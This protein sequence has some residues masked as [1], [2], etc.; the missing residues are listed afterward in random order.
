MKCYFNHEEKYIN[1]NPNPTKLPL[2]YQL[3]ID[4]N[5]DTLLVNIACCSIK[6]LKYGACIL[7]V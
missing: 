4:Y 2:L 6:H 5:Q 7:K 3:C 1:Y